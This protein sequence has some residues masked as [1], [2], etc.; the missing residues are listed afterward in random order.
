MWVDNS[1][2][3][4][5]TDQYNG[6]VETGNS[7]QAIPAPFAAN[8]EVEPKQPSRNNSALP[9]WWTETNDEEVE[10]SAVNTGSNQVQQES[11]PASLNA[12]DEP[13]FDLSHLYR[14]PLPSQED[15]PVS[16][17]PQ[18]NQNSQNSNGQSFFGLGLETFESVNDVAPSAPIQ[19]GHSFDRFMQ[20][21]QALEGFQ[22]AQQSEAPVAY[23]WQN[24]YPSEPEKPTDKLEAASV[25]LS[26]FDSLLLKSLSIK[27]NPSS[28]AI[29]ELVVKMNWI[30]QRHS[31]HSH[32]MVK[33]RDKH[34][35]ISFPRPSQPNRTRKH[36]PISQQP[37]PPVAGRMGLHLVMMRKKVSKPT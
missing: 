34:P 31:I 18:A 1:G 15:V 19:N 9:S 24:N 37:T 3:S 22:D 6:N 33:L 4:R 16:S 14:D 27:V 35:S 21:E 23:E 12:T 8:A 7:V 28:Q 25:G 11:I 10:E 20:R 17:A 5:I 29:P 30:M 32:Q 2:D 26:A 36:L 13:Q